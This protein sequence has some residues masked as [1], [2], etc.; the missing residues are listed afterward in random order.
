MVNSPHADGNW[1]RTYSG[2]QFSYDHVETN[3]IYIRDIAHSLA[4]ICRY[5]GHA[6]EFYSVAQHSMLVASVLPPELQFEGLLHDAAEAYTGDFPAPMKWFLRKQG[7][8]AFGLLEKR[9]EYAVRSHF[10][11]PV[12]ESPEVK[13]ADMRMCNTE[14]RDLMRG[15]EGYTDLAPYEFDIMPRSAKWCEQA[16]LEQYGALRHAA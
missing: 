15:A 8:D 14:M 10:G 5:N 12:M 7:N 6:S 16:F 13:A 2:A 1:I 3:P 4:H 9:I 11:L